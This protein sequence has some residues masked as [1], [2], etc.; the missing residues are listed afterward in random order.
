MTSCQNM[1]DFSF[2][3]TFLTGGLLILCLVMPPPPLSLWKKSLVSRYVQRKPFSRHIFSPQTTAYYSI[4]RTLTIPRLAIKRISCLTVTNQN[5]EAR[6]VE[7]QNQDPEIRWI[8]NKPRWQEI[9]SYNVAAKT[10][11]GQWQSLKAQSQ[12][13]RTFEC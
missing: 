9:A 1:V 12:I 5:E 8:D 13:K 3:C 7:A 11:W 2:L 4:L 6:I 10:Y